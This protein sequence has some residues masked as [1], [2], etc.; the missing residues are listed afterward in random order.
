MIIMTLEMLSKEM[1]AAMKNKDKLRKD[2][3][4]ALIGSVKKAGIDKGCRDN[5]SESLVTEVILKEQKTINE[6]IDTCPA[7]RIDT[8]AEYK[9]R[10]A[11]ITEF[12]PTM[13]TEDEI[14]MELSTYC[15]LEG[16]EL[17]KANRAAIMRGFM[18]TIKGRADGKLANKVITEMLI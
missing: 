9:A 14:A 15:S 7:D 8:L 3:I 18:P 11:V 10:A 4:S 16:L 5:I 12:A 6:M 2:T 13:M 17:T 1:I